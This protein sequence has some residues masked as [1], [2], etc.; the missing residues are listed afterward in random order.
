MAFAALTRMASLSLSCMIASKV[1]SAVAAV[2][3]GGRALLWAA[4]AEPLAGLR[5]LVW[6]LGTACA[7]GIIST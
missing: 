2:T 1:A 4:A 7:A 6:R 5:V 3:R